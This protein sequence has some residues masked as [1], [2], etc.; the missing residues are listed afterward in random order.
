[1]QPWGDSNDGVRERLETRQ[2]G[3]VWLSVPD[4][5]LAD[6]GL[7]NDAFAWQAQDFWSSNDRL[8]DSGCL[9][10]RVL[11]E[12]IPSNKP[13]HQIN[14]VAARATSAFTFRLL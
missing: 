2:F 1:M 10:G 14:T 4:D 9:R 7:K 5:R 3:R 8:I 13:A 6:P 12:L 11:N